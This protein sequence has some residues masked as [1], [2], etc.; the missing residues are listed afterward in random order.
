MNKKINGIVI[1]FDG[2]YGRILSSDR[3]HYLLLSKEII[4][5]TVKEGD[6]VEFIP[7][8]KVTPTITSL[9]ARFVT[10]K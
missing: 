6:M 8:R 2:T 1:D 4:D 7:D 9:I 10:K 3:V 5:G